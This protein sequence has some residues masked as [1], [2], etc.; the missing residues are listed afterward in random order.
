MKWSDSADCIL[1]LSFESEKSIKVRLVS[2]FGLLKILD[3]FE[4][5]KM[6]IFLLGGPYQQQ[7]L[8][9]DVRRILYEFVW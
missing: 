6:R 2:R 3:N 9:G 8:P 1:G 5:A 7:R 4:D